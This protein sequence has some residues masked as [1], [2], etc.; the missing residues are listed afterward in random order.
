MESLETSPK[1]NDGGIS[2]I[3]DKIC[4]FLNFCSFK[5]LFCR[6]YGDFLHFVLSLRLTAVVVRS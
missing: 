6:I 5:S 4:A 1:R 3:C 2:F